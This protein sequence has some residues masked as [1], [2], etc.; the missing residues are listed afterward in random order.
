[1]LLLAKDKIEYE[2]RHNGKTTKQ[3]I[4]DVAEALQLD[5]EIVRNFIEG[6][7]GSSRRSKR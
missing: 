3:A 2:R 6:R 1:M 4:D 7:R 5:S